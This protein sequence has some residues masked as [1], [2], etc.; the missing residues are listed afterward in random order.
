MDVGDSTIHPNTQTADEAHILHWNGAEKPWKLAPRTLYSEKFTRYVLSTQKLYR[1]LRHFDDLMRILRYVPRWESM[2]SESDDFTLVI[3][4]Q[5]QRLEALEQVLRHVS[6]CEQLYEVLLVWNQVSTCAIASRHCRWLTRRYLQVGVPCPAALFTVA[7][8]VGIEMRCL[9]Q[10][11]N[12][13]QAR[14]LIASEIST[15]AVLHHDDDA[16]IRL[17]DMKLAFKVWKRHRDQIVGFEPRVHRHD[18]VTGWSYGFHL[19]EGLGQRS[20]LCVSLLV[21]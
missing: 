4:T 21:T 5:G 20:T 14:L 11:Q 7:A 8:Q 16:L 15:E 10:N 19:S 9:P 12:D 6:G 2:L 1:L 13:V 3:V 17:E 18:P